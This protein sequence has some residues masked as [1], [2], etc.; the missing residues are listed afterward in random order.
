[1][2]V[3]LKGKKVGGGVGSGVCLFRMSPLPQYSGANGYFDYVVIDFQGPF[4][5]ALRVVAFAKA[6]LCLD[7]SPGCVGMVYAN[8]AY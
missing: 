8:F 1:M 4:S 5:D 3:R 7:V 2:A 6:F